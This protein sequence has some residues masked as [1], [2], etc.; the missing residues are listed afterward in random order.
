VSGFRNWLAIGTGV[1]IELAANRLR[2]VITRVRPGG[3]DVLGAHTIENHHEKPAAEWGAEYASF[4]R[5]HGAGHLSATV[6]LPRREVIVRLV[7]LPGVAAKDTEA[8]LNLQIDTLH[9]HA[10][11][12]V[13][14]TWARIN[15]TAVLVGVV[16]QAYVERQVELLT[17]AGIK[18]SSFTF[19]AAATYGALRLLSDPPRSG[20][21]GL[22][23]TEDGIEA[24]GE[25]PAK[26]V[27]SANY[28][29]PAE[30]VAALATAELRL[31]E[32]ITSHE[33]AGILPSPRRAPADG[34]LDRSYV[35]AYLAA[36]AAACPRRALPANLLPAAQR[37]SSSRLIYV[38]TLALGLVMIIGL[39]VLALHGR[40]EDQK[41][42]KSI[43]AEIARLEPR[44]K[45]VA[46]LDQRVERARGQIQMLDGFH[47]Q[48]KADMDALRE[49][50]RVIAAPAWLN[51]LEL[52]RSSLL[53]AGEADQA[54]GLLKAIDSSPQFQNSEF[55]VPLSRIGNVEIFRIRAAREGV[56]R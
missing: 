43:E 31:P 13:S 51:L 26:P 18:I 44:A 45:M 5:K 22:M 35:L 12:D 38:P 39:V 47:A 49:A 30:R 55:V 2:I 1:G 41:L 24:Y 23:E 3:V 48:T 9:P 28:Q 46:A 21:L 17:E 54:T 40:Y 32:N 15:P 36:L 6:L 34:G 19:S 25:S 10:E 7:T 33:L 42:L 50:T 14:W 16:K 27:Y 20:F 53:V 11:S 52:T 56:Q 29:Q 8:A 37:I 4:L